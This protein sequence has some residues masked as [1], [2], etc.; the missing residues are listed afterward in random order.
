[1]SKRVTINDVARVAGVSRQTV[2]R[3]LN[4]KGEIDAGTKQRVL[5]AARELGYRPSR[6]ARGLVRQDS[7]TIGL[8]P[9]RPTSRRAIACT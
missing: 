6:F 8:V 7:T 2:S 4:D 9:T 5:D 3:A 1:M